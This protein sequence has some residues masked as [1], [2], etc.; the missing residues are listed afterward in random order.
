MRIW[1]NWNSHTLLVGIQNGIVTLENSLMISY[2]VKHVLTI[3][4]KSSISRYLPKR[5]ESIRQKKI[6]HAWTWVRALVWE[7]PTCHGAA[8]PVSHNC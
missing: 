7:D 4:P 5:N 1:S 3:Q 8:G 2:K 6:L